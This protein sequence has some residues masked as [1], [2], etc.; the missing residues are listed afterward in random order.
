M[1]KKFVMV[2]AMGCLA[3]PAKH[4]SA[5][6]M[7]HAKRGRTRSTDAILL[8]G[9]VPGG[10]GLGGC[11]EVVELRQQPVRVGDSHGGTFTSLGA[12]IRCRSPGRCRHGFR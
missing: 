6:G 10:A 3:N 2:T 9:A 1:G 5:S 12:A 7:I 4:P 8:G 11:G